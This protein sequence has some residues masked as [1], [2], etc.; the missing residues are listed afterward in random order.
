MKNSDK[1]LE[2]GCGEAIEDPVAIIKSRDDQ[3]MYWSSE[4]I[5]I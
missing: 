4:T 1:R 3:G 2:G 5:F